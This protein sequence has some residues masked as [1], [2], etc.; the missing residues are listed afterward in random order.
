MSRIKQAL[1]CFRG[2]RGAPWTA[3]N[4]AIIINQPESRLWKTGLLRGNGEAL[5]IIALNPK[6][7][8][9]PQVMEARWYAAYT[10]PC[11]EKRVAQHLSMRGVEYFLPLYS[12]ARKWKN[13]CRVELERPLFPGYV[14]VRIPRFERVKVLDVPSVLSIVG[15]G[16]EPEALPDADI[17]GLRTSMAHRR[18][19]PYP[20]LRTGHRV[21]VCTGPLAGLSGVLVRFKSSMRVVLTLDLIMQSVAVEL[22]AEDLEPMSPAADA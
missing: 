21:R 14:F 10:A 7:L 11:H 15:R 4:L 13:G 5:S 20:Y 17:E 9:Q 2:A 8:V 1:A 6:N 22:A 19:E 12:S 3:C 16:R 18:F